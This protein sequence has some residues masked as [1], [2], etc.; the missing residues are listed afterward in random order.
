SLPSDPARS[1]RRCEV[2][3]LATLDSGAGSPPLYLPDPAAGT[4]HEDD[5][6]QSLKVVERVAAEADEVSRPSNI[7][8]VRSHRFQDRLALQSRRGQVRRL[9]SVDPRR[10]RAVAQ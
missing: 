8:R 5:V 3:G 2:Y 10:Y 1:V 7:D 9:A 6:A 4:H